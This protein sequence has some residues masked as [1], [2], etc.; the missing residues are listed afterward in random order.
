MIN[1][2]YKILQLGKLAIIYKNINEIK[3]LLC[4]WHKR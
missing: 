4:E 3:Q 2:L 1:Y